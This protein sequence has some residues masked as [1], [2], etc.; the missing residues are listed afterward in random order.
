MGADFGRFRKDLWMAYPL[1]PMPTLADIVAI[2][3]DQYGYRL[4]EIELNG[5]RGTT[6]VRFLTRGNGNA[7]SFVP[8]PDL[9]DETRLPPSAVRSL[10]TQIGIQ[11]SDVGFTLGWTG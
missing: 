1:A 7:D 5:P 9:P 3:K 10:C 4:E 6:K 8:L 2:A 11:P